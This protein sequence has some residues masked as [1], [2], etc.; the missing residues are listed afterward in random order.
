M[1]WGSYSQLLNNQLAALNSG[2]ARLS[3]ELAEL[4]DEMAGLKAEFKRDKTRKDKQVSINFEI[5]MAQQLPMMLEDLC[6][7]TLSL[8]DRFVRQ[9]MA[10]HHNKKAFMQLEHAI[11]TNGSF[12]RERGRLSPERQKCLR[13]NA[14]SVEYNDTLS[15]FPMCMI[16]HIDKVAKMCHSKYDVR[17]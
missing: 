10:K 4:K 12:T 14:S 13:G 16:V 11:E 9:V 2:L 3:G 6:G 8:K 17:M 5:A 7:I 1:L 15:C